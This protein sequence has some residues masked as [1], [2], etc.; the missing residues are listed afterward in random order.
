MFKLSPVDRFRSKF[1]N[2]SRKHLLNPLNHI[3]PPAIS[4]IGTLIGVLCEVR[5]FFSNDLSP[6][7]FSRPSRLSIALFEILNSLAQFCRPTLSVGCS[8]ISEVDLTIYLIF[9]DLLPVF[10][11]DWNILHNVGKSSIH[12]PCELSRFWN[13]TINLRMAGHQICFLILIGSWPTCR[14]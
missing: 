7:E 13:A 10:L 9:F 5:W 6:V 2:V 4:V 11:T 3:F 12:Q 1:E 8:I 14:W